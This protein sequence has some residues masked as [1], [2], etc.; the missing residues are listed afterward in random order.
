MVSEANR[1]GPNDFKEE[2]V[3]KCLLLL[4]FTLLLPSRFGY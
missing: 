4:N 3:V 2:D 1:I